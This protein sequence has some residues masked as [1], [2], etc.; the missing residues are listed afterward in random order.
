MGAFDTT[1]PLVAA[2]AVGLAK[3]CMDEAAKYAMGRS[4]SIFLLIFHRAT[5]L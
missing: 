1:R 2:A 5:A 3:R 4:R